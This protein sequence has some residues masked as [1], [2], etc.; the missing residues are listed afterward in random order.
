MMLESTDQDS[1]RT[2]FGKGSRRP[3]VDTLGDGKSITSQ[4]D[5][6][7]YR[8]KLKDRINVVKVSC[9]RL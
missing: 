3:S 7:S 4:S 8:E 1:V 9:S 2:R 6:R 5:T